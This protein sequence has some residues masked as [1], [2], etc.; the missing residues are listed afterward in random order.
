MQP[1]SPRNFFKNFLN[2]YYIYLSNIKVVVVIMMIIIIIM[3]MMMFII[4]I[5]NEIHIFK[6]LWTVYNLLHISHPSTNNSIRN[7]MIFPTGSSFRLY[8]GKMRS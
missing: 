1:V 4:I 2:R 6:R 7:K 5:K 8:E 3:I